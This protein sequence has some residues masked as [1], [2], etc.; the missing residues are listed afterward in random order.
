M[1]ITPKTSPRIKA[2]RKKMLME[3][4]GGGVKFYAMVPMGIKSYLALG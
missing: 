3:F 2:E 1:L 4:G